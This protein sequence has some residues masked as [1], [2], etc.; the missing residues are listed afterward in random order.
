MT[1]FKHEFHGSPQPT[2]QFKCTPGI[3][4]RRHFEEDQFRGSE[5][6]DILESHGRNGTRDEA[7]PHDI[8]FIA[9]GKGIKFFETKED[10][11]EWTTE[12]NGDTRSCSCSQ[13]L[14]LLS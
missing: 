12:R 6:I 2:H 4:N 8:A 3:D 1:H 5:W 9:E 14:S 7:T 13:K 11:S 10:A